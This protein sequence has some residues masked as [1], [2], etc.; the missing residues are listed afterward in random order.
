M[1]RCRCQFKGE[2]LTRN[3]F[4]SKFYDVVRRRCISMRY[5]IQK[6]RNHRAPCD[7]ADIFDEARSVSECPR[8]FPVSIQ[9]RI[10]DI[11]ETKPAA[12]AQRAR[13]I[14]KELQSD[15]GF[16]STEKCDKKTNRIFLTTDSDEKGSSLLPQLA[17]KEK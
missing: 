8:T 5:K 17:A 12:R 6:A 3:E 4:S 9:R 16:L 2:R 14:I 1:V 15:I 10:F 13:E 7:E 11:F